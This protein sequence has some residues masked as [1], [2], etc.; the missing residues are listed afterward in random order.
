MILAAR[1]APPA[2]AADEQALPAPASARGR[3]QPPTTARRSTLPTSC[4]LD[5]D[6]G[7]G[8]GPESD[9]CGA[10]GCPGWCASD[11]SLHHLADGRDVFVSPCQRVRIED[12]PG[13]TWEPAVTV[14]A[15]ASAAG[16]VLWRAEFS[17]RTPDPVFASLLC[18]LARDLAEPNPRDQRRALRGPRVESASA[19]LPETGWYRQ[20][21]GLERSYRGATLAWTLWGLDESGERWQVRFADATPAHLVAAAC[22]P[23]VEEEER[24]RAEAAE[25]ALAAMLSTDVDDSAPA[26]DEQPAEPAPRSPR[27]RVKGAPL[28][29]V[30]R[31]ARE[32]LPGDGPVNIRT[33]SAAVRAQGFGISTR[34]AQEAAAI[35]KAERADRP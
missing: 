31:I 29:T 21:F 20:E 2:R 14:T 28:E 7:P 24:R 34:R 27:K 10:D 32:D 17:A 6:R 18:A 16:D 35:L 15:Y 1:G 13:A 30:L 33:V 25:R 11:W 5:P 9:G 22:Q 26:V 23:L 8:C 4:P 12:D 3:G 19:C